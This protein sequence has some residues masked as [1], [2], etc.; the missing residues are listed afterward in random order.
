MSRSH[1]AVA[2]QYGDNVE[3]LNPDG[4]VADPIGQEQ[5]VYDEL[6]NKI[7]VLIGNR[8]EELILKE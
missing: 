3:M 5:P 7:E 1:L 8:L 2:G 4:P 6:A